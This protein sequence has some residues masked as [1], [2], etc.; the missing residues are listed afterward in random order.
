MEYDYENKWYIEYTKLSNG[1]TAMI[2]FDRFEKGRTI[3]YYVT[4]GIAN[5]KKFLKRWLMEQEGNGDFSMQCTGKCG[6]EGLLWA[7]RKIEEFMEEHKSWATNNV[8]TH[9]VVVQGADAHRHRIYKH[10]LK[11]LGFVEE[12]DPDWGWLIAKKF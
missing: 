1:Q 9:K 8:Y 12:R 10:F 7:Y 4:F 5:K 2:V 11:R 6:T 3:Y